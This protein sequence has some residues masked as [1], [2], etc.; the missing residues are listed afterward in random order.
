[1]ADDARLADALLAAGTAALLFVGVFYAAHRVVIWARRR[2]KRA[3]VIGAALAPFIA[4]G[5]VVDPDFRIV[6]EA[7]QLKMREEDEPGDPPNPADR[8]I[9]SQEI[10]VTTGDLQNGRSETEVAVAT[11]SRVWRPVL[12]RAIAFVLG[13][14]ALTTLVVES[15]IL[16]SAY[17]GRAGREIRESFSAFEWISM[18]V[19]SAVLLAS[20]FLLFRLRKSSVWLFGGYVG[21]GVLLSL[22][23]YLLLG[24]NPYLDLRVTFVSVPVAL[25]VLAYM[26]RLSKQ[27]KLV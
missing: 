26:R 15:T 16:L 27:A 2:S 22:G 6:Q 23:H 24:P 25:A 20:M 5:N 17:S 13:L 11:K 10:Q 19:M 18:Y 4:M 3:Y 8:S 7:K 12:A 9:A 21:L 1:M 14:M